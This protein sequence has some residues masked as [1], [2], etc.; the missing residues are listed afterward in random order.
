MFFRNGLLMGGGYNGF[1][2]SS[3]SSA[4]PAAACD[5]AGLF[6]RERFE[7]VVVYVGCRLLSGTKT[8]AGRNAP[9]ATARIACFSAAYAAASFSSSSLWQRAHRQ[10][11]RALLRAPQVG[12]ITIPADDAGQI[13]RGPS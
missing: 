5:P 9:S 6:M 12:G 4:R 11:R 2:D 3:C 8:R 7:L 13:A 10:S 1:T